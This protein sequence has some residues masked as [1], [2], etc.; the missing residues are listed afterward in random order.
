MDRASQVLAQDVPSGVPD[1]QRYQRRSEAAVL[2][3]SLGC[4]E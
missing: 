4:E 2:A 3:A 1:K